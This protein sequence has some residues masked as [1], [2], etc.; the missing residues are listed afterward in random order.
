MLTYRVISSKEE[1]Y[2]L[3]STL[4]AGNGGDNSLGDIYAICTARLHLV[5]VD[6]HKQEVSSSLVTLC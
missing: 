2:N 3:F 1:T 6:S 4:K 5:L